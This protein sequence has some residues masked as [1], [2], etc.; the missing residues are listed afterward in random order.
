MTEQDI[1]NQ[2]EIEI[3]K[4]HP[5]IAGALDEIQKTFELANTPVAIRSSTLTGI[6]IDVLAKVNATSAFMYNADVNPFAKR[7]GET[8]ERATILRYT[9]IKEKYNVHANT[10]KT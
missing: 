1:I 8:V 4:H 2:T 9:E 7:A 6:L 3:Q 5:K 10:P